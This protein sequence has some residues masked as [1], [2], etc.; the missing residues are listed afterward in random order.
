[1]LEGENEMKKI[2]LAITMLGVYLH[3]TPI[4][5]NNTGLVT[6]LEKFTPVCTY[7]SKTIKQPRHIRQ[8]CQKYKSR[9]D[10]I[11]K[12]GYRLDRSIPSMKHTHFYNGKMHTCTAQSRLNMEHSKLDKYYDPI[13]IK[14]YITRLFRLDKLR[15]KI[16]EDISLEKTKARKSYD[17]EYHEK[18]IRKGVIALYGSDY[19]F[20]TEHKEV[21]ANADNPRYIEML[22][23]YVSADDPRYIKMRNDKI[24]MVKP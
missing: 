17:I 20:M 4:T 2:L 16:I 15:D 8:Q 13:L 24:K 11:L 6:K 7:Y 5:L 22:E 12:T 14:Q 21:Y 9:L 19:I 18:L 10:G 23:V 3:A 1:M